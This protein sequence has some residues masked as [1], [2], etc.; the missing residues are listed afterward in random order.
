MVGEVRLD[1]AHGLRADERSRELPQRA[2]GA[3]HLHLRRVVLTHQLHDRHRVGQQRA[4]Q[5]LAD[6]A[7]GCDVCSRRAVDEHRL[8]R[9]DQ[10]QRLLGEPLLGVDRHFQALKEGVLMARQPWKHR[11]A[12]RA[13]GD[14]PPLELVEIAACGHRRDA[15]LRFEPGHRDA[16]LLPQTLRNQPPALSRKHGSPGV[17]HARTCVIGRRITVIYHIER[18]DRERQLCESSS[19]SCGYSS[20][21]LCTAQKMQYFCQPSAR[22]LQGEGGADGILDG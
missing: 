15:E 11:A 17:G 21:Y 1:S 19:V 22:S 12:V 9:L 4:L 16:A 14:A 10:L 20:G 18:P 13:A 7:A 6:D 2:A 5:V 3:D 8:A